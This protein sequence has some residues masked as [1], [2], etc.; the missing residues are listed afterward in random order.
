[1]EAIS[2][3]KERA[4]NRIKSGIKLNPST[5]RYDYN[6]DLDNNI[7]KCFVSEDRDGFTID[8]GEVTGNFDCSLL[9]LTSLKGAP[10]KVGGDF[11]CDFNKLS[12][13]EEAPQTVGG[14]FYCRDNKLT[15]LKGAPQEIGEDFYCSR[16][17]D[18]HSLEGI[19]KVKGRIYKGLSF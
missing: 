17:P 16:N 7:I 14:N 18:L 5:N 15:S 10:Q 6:G 19:G 4:I 13:L 11:K 12:S 3:D 1:M 9:H 2:K 8:F